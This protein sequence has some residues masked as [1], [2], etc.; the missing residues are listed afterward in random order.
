[1][2][3]CV[4]GKTVLYYVRGGEESKVIIIMWHVVKI[5]TVLGT[6]VRKINASKITDFLLFY[7]F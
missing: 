2:T 3:C 5:L 7:G 4:W 6:G 1:M